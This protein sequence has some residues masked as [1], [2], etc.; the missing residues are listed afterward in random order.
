MRR[1]VRAILRDAEISQSQIGVAIV[2]DPAIAKLHEE[3]LDDPT[4]TDVLSFILE[5]SEQCLE[6]EVV[7]S[8]DTAV[9]NAV[10]YQST[11]DDELLLYVIH[12]MLHLVGYDD[13]T[14]AKRAVMREQEQKYLTYTMPIDTTETRRT[15]STQ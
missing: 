13:T 4:P 9:A 2:D 10:R 5:R 11:P 12:G 3:F 8:A 6:G 15:R 14:P 7:V 1:A